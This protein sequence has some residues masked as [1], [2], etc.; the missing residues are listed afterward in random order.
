MQA[1][2]GFAAEYIA[3][4]FFCEIA[5]QESEKKMEKTRK[6]MDPAFC[7]NLSDIFE[8]IPAWERGLKE[9]G[10]LV[11]ALPEVMG[12]LGA[13]AEALKQGLDRIFAAAEKLELVYVYTML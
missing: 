7:W 5:I 3:P 1:A 10:D 8:D 4:A 2:R 9:A 6:Q 13:S 11:A 12:T